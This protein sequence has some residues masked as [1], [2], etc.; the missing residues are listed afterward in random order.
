MTFLYSL[1]LIFTKRVIFLIYK[2][3]QESQ[4]HISTLSSC[5]TLKYYK[6]KC[7]TFISNESYLFCM[8]MTAKELN[9]NE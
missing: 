1:N 8:V 9:N 5:N 7:N 3:L 2:S 6:W 4:E